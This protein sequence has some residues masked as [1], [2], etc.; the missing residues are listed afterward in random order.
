MIPQNN[1]GGA[2]GTCITL[3]LLAMLG[4]N[5]ILPAQS[6]DP[7]YTGP[8]EEVSGRYSIRVYL[9]YVQTNSDPWASNLGQTELERRTARSFDVLNA[10]Y[11]PHDIYFIPGV[12]SES[13]YSVFTQVNQETP[14]EYGD[15]LTVHVFSDDNLS[16][17]HATGQVYASTLPAR[18]L[19]VRGMEDNIPGSNLPVLIHEVGHCLGLA[20]TF[21]FTNADYSYQDNAWCTGGDC[22]PGQSG[23]PDDCCG[24]LVNDSQRNGISTFIKLATD[25]CCSIEPA[26]VGQEIF[27]NYMSYSYPTICRNKFTDQQVARMRKYLRNPPP[28]LAPV[29]VQ[30]EA[31]AA[32]T[33]V[34]WN[35]AQSKF[36]DI[37]VPDG[38]S[39]TIDAPLSMAPGAYIIIRRGG[40]LIINSTIT[41]ACSGMWGGIIVEGDGN[42]AQTALMAEIRAH[43]SAMDIGGGKVI[44]NFALDS[45]GPKVDSVLTWTAHLARFET[46]LRLARHA[47][48][49]GNLIEYDQWLANI[50]VRNELS[51][52]QASVLSDFTQV[53]AVLRPYVQSSHLLHKLPGT[54]LDSLENRAS[55]CTEPGFIAKTVLQRNG[56]ETVTQCTGYAPARPAVSQ[57][58]PAFSPDIRIYPNPNRGTFRVEMPPHAG[59]LRLGLYTADGRLALD[60]TLVSSA[61]IDI[62][63]ALP[64]IYVCRI[65]GGAGSFATKLVVSR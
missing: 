13:C 41:A 36:T 4:V 64:G 7:A 51:T 22:A 27:S 28:V 34:T 55:D 48:F 10:A 15:G 53:L 54:A 1:G 57:A 24:D 61:T 18:V 37:I 65:F 21:A 3:L 38:A 16:A 30:A 20:H 58:G 9:I 44:R 60:R 31:I 17:V 46:D 49:A 14:P 26:N 40:V 11:N 45:I 19:W 12:V 8:Y 63:N 47:F 62:P 52:A 39:L 6:F 32:G 25:C 2:F 59:P 35:T 56:R 23:S 33:P 50:P 42:A 43:R 5:G 29:L